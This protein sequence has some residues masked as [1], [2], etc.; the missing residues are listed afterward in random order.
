M[1]DAVAD[2][3]YKRTD[4]V[5]D[6]QQPDVYQL[7]A[8]CAALGVQR[9]LLIYADRQPHTTQRV[10]LPSYNHHIDID[11]VGIDLS[12]PWDVVL[13]QARHVAGALEAIA[14]AA[15]LSSL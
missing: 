10:D 2:V 1:F 4:D 11:A 5:G 15:P 8:C 3:K 9:G 14:R 7:F 12:K 6:F 13:K